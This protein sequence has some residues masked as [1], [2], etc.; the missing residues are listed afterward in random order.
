VNTIVAHHPLRQYYT[1]ESPPRLVERAL[2]RLAYVALWAFVFCIPWA[3]D[4][5]VMAGYG[6]GRWIGLVAFGIGLMRVAVSRRCRRPSAVHYEM[7]AFV[8][9]SS[10]SIF[11][12]VDADATSTR[13]GTYL[14]LLAA[15]WLVWELAVVEARVVGLLQSYVLGT[16]VSATI[17]LFNFLAGRTA[18]DVFYEQTGRQRWHDSRFTITGINENDLGLMLALSLPMTLYL[19][20]R[21]K[22]P[23][24]L[25]YWVQI[26]L[27][28]TALLLTGSR[29]SAMA[30]MVA[31]TMYPLTLSRLPP[32]QRLLS[33]LA[34]SAAVIASVLI[35]PKDTWIR[36][37]SFGREVS[38]G[39][40]THR[41]L[42]WE[43]GLQAFRDHA[44]LGVGAGAY[45]ASVL[46]AIDIPYVAHNTYLSVLVELG[47]VGG[48]VLVGLL[49]SVVWCAV[50]MR[51]LERRLW[52]TLLA[53]W[54]MG[55]S[56]LTWEYRKPTWL[57]FGL[58]VAHAYAR[59]PE[60]PRL[61][62]L[63]S[64]HTIPRATLRRR[65]L[66]PVEIS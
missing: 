22:G 63:P 41:T 33:I 35:V 26:P 37:L 13:T 66:P 38:E 65:E 4:L 42:I 34:S 31:C 60:R 57:L 44:F 43:A 53:T 23:V 3:E 1:P 29:G 62:R 9:L 58:L 52:I 47:A 12:S 46:K 20:T 16:Y 19:L 30:A 17:V 28:L 49:A 10:L 51:G 27:C 14:Q 25:L 36:L 18:A 40:L 39:T 55:V 45:G 50:Q 61:N 59:R 8:L 7:G 64:F 56:A 48:L 32:A 5:P 54:G 21:R 24:T 6:I 15:V 11:W 2:E